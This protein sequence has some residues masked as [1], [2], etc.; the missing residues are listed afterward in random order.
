MLNRYIAIGEAARRWHRERDCKQLRASTWVVRALPTINEHGP[1]RVDAI[2]HSDGAYFAPDAY[3]PC[4]VCAQPYAQALFFFPDTKGLVPFDVA[5]AGGG[6]AFGE[7]VSPAADALCSCTLWPC[8]H[9]APDGVIVDGAHIP[10]S[11]LD[12]RG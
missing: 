6:V 11:L 4:R 10:A 12:E 5:S 1:R 8:R 7:G 2:V 9:V 3:G